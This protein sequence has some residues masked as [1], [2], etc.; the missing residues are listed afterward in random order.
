MDGSSLWRGMLSGN[1]GWVWT[2]TVPGVSAMGRVEGMPGCADDVPVYD[3]DGMMVV[4][5]VFW[6]ARSPPVIWSRRF[7]LDTD[8]DRVWRMVAMGVLGGNVKSS[9]LSSTNEMSHRWS[10]VVRFG[11]VILH[12]GEKVLNAMERHSLWP[13]QATPLSPEPCPMPAILKVGDRVKL[14]VE[15]PKPVRQ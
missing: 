15:I 11:F 6:R 3:F 1:I 4:I 12:P 7:Q 5:F 9:L 8:D 2:L 13:C 14:W 10:V